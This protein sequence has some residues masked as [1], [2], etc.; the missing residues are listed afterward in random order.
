[1][2][3]ASRILSKLHHSDLFFPVDAI[4]DELVPV[5][6]ERSLRAVASHVYS[7]VWL[8]KEGDFGSL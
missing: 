3:V 6:H 4:M 2:A 1:M 8:E 5:D 7:V